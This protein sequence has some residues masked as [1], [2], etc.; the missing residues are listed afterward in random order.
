[1]VGS[2]LPAPNFMSHVNA[3]GRG[4]PLMTS[5]QPE[6]VQLMRAAL[7]E[8][9]TRIPAEQATVSVKAAVAEL[10]LKTAAQGQTTL[11]GLV[12]AGTEHIQA[13]VLMLT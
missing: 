2:I 7:E 5:Y 9:M 13:I 8:V 6:V 3:A 4:R 11:D 1:M 12:A 10:I